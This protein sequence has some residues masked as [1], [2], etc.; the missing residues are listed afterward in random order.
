M[1]KLMIAATPLEAWAMVLTYVAYVLVGG[2]W[3]ELDDEKV[4]ALESPPTRFP[5][6]VFLARVVDPPRRS[7]CI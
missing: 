4:V 2:D 1:Q 6:I 3:F 5:Y 7:S